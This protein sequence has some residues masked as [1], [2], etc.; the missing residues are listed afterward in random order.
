MQLQ[1]ASKSNDAQ[2]EVDKH[3]ALKI[4]E[5]QPSILQQVDDVFC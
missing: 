2:K 5:M 3:P 4:I 1:K